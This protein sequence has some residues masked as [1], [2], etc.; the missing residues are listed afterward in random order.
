MLNIRCHQQDG[1]NGAGIVEQLTNP[2]KL[3]SRS[4]VCTLPSPIPGHAVR[5]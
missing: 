1:F 3:W 2:V 4:E 5:G